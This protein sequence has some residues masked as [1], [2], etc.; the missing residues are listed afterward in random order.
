MQ[1]SRA[2][3]VD[4][5]LSLAAQGFR[6]FPIRPNSKIP[7]RELPWKEA[8]TS[9]T[10]QIKSWW[11]ENP[12]YNI[13][14]ATGA[15][16]LV[17][18]VDVKDDKPGRA[19]LEMLELTDFPES[20]RV[21]TPS[22]GEH[23]Y[24]K[25]DHDYGQ[26][27]NLPDYPGIDIRCDGGYVLGPGST[28]DGKPYEASEA[29]IEPI[30]SW[31]DNYL[32]KVKPRRSDRSS[33]PLIELDRPENI[34][35]AKDWLVNYA[36]EAIEGC[37]GDETTY[38]VACRCRDFGLSEAATLEAMLDDWNELKASPPWTPDELSQK[39][40]NA[41]SYGQNAPGSKTAAAEFD[42]VDIDEGEP[43]STTSTLKFRW[44]LETVADLRKLPPTNWLVDGWIPEETTGIVYGKWGSGKTFVVFDLALSLAYGFADWHGAA[45]PGT[46]QTVLI[47]A[48]EGQKGFQDRI[49]AFKKRHEIVND[50]DKLL[51][52]RKAISFLDAAEFESFRRELQSRKLGLSLTLIDTVARVVPGGKLNESGDVLTFMNRCDLLREATGATTIGIH[53][54]NKSGDVYGSVFFEANADFAY[55]IK[56]EG[57]EKAP[58]SSGSVYCAKLKDGEDRWNRKLRYRKVFLDDELEKASLVLEE[59]DND[60]GA[61]KSAELKPAQKCLKASLAVA[62]KEKGAAIPWPEWEAT[63]FRRVNPNWRSGDGRPKG[64]SVPNLNKC[65]AAL[66]KKG[67]V[68]H[69]SDD[70]YEI[71][72]LI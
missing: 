30:P 10:D 49:D 2:D 9:D 1:A 56:R 63:H 39:V 58:L 65:R 14:V 31:F 70:T 64:C 66:I 29:P 36:P 8:A 20:Y 46:P 32:R 48:R 4:H 38:K 42:A 11:T 68:I 45:L 54:E 19:S 17:V 37:A 15:G 69:N 51:F 47:I 33:K 67:H 41:F 55:E 57:H 12:D 53:H 50:P 3:K 26:K 72:D 7:K 71:D 28:I 44:P 40:A 23:I 5:A 60:A 34:D 24:L 27:A 13:G 25:I 6:V 35:K 43:P 21:K 22:G 62:A 52:M 16:T 59:V 61:S 18:D